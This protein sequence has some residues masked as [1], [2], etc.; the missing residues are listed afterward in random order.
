MTARKP[1][2]GD[3]PLELGPKAEVSEKINTNPLSF[4]LRVVLGSVGGE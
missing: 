4:L 3:S 1:T 2:A